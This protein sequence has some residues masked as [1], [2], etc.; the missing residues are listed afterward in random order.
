MIDSIPMTTLLSV[1]P[2]LAQKV[3]RLQFAA[4]LLKAGHDPKNVRQR[5]QSCFDCSQ[6][7]AWRTVERAMDIC[8]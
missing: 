5:V 1:N 4:N 3:Q 7:T 2:A 6:P 8:A